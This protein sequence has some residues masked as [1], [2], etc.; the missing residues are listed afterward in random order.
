MVEHHRVV[1]MVDHFPVMV[2]YN[3]VFAHLIQFV[4]LYKQRVVGIHHNQKGA[5]GNVVLCNARMDE[6]VVIPIFAHL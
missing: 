1:N 6:K 3:H 4:R 5:A 2:N